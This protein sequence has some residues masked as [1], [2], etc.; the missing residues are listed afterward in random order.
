MWVGV[1]GTGSNVVKI[2]MAIRM[3]H[4]SV[5]RGQHHHDGI[6]NPNQAVHPRLFSVL[7][8]VGVWGSSAVRGANVAIM[9]DN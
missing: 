9:G 6:L 1:S 7:R 4:Q 8:E 5:S 2:R 3:V